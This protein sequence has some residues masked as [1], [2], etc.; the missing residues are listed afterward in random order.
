MPP[1]ATLFVT[2]PN[3]LDAGGLPR[4]SAT[5]VRVGKELSERPDCFALLSFE[6]RRRDPKP[7]SP[8]DFRSSK[9]SCNSASTEALMPDPSTSTHCKLH[10]LAFRA[11]MR[12][13]APSSRIKFARTSSVW[14]PQPRL[15]AFA[16]SEVPFTPILFRCRPRRSSCFSVGDLCAKRLRSEANEVAPSSVTAFPP[17]S[18]SRRVNCS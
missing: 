16:I 18:K 17:S 10:F 9:T 3:V 8:P 5:S 11:C 15:K 1:G 2:A 12:A 14:R 7:A 4:I 13:W 6:V